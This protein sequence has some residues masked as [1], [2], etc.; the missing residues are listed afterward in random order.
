[1]VASLDEQ[2]LRYLFETVTA[3][4]VRAAADKLDLNPSSISRQIALLEKEVAV[5]LIER[6][7]R[8]VR[9]SEAGKLLLDYYR[10]QRSDQADL[11]AKLQEMHNL[12]R[13]H[14][15]LVLGEGFV[16]D[17]MS[18][19]LQAFRRRHPKLTLSLELAGTN[20]VMRLVAEDSAHIGLVYNP[21]P[22]PRIRSH[23]AIRQPMCAI[24]W[25]GHP[26][27]RSGRPLRLG[28]LLDHPIALMRADYGTR[29]IVQM[30]EFSEKIRFAPTLTTGSISVLKHFV[31][32]CQ[33]ITLLPAFA[34]T[35]EIAAGDLAAVAIDHPVMANAEAHIVTRLGRQLP[36]AANRLLRHLI[37]GMKAFRASD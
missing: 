19:P 34:A 1:M 32:A 29:Q 22:E 11:F 30:A 18:E 6:H 17:L 25:P 37:S 26:L 5:A 14:I 36:P 24:V 27:V 16:S 9:A 21:P 13:G 12:Q 8:G 31:K 3:G 20:D 33:A 35:Q 15:D 23:A 4:S 28:E 10:R 2:R 7:S